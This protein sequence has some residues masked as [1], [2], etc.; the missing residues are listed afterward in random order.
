MQYTKP[1]PRKQDDPA[2]QRQHSLQINK[3]IGSLLQDSGLK[4]VKPDGFVMRT[5][6]YTILLLGMVLLLTGKASGQT[7]TLQGT[8]SLTQCTAVEG[9]NEI[10]YVATS[11]VLRIVNLDSPTQPV[12]S[13]QVATGAGTIAALEAWGNYVYG[14]G[15][16]DGLIIVQASNPASPQLIIRYQPGSSVRDI[17]VYDTLVAYANPA[18]VTLLG[19]RN[20]ANPHV[21]ATYGRAS[22]WV[23]FS[24]NGQVLH[25][26]S[27][28][29][30][31]SL[32]V[33]RNISGGD[34]T[35]SLALDEE[36]STDALTPVSVAGDRVDFVRSSTLVVLNAGTY[37]LFAQRQSS[38]AIRAI[39][40]GNGFCFTALT[41]GELEYLDQRTSPI[42]LVATAVAPASPN[43]IALA[44]S[45]TQPLL[46]VAHNSGVS[47]YSYSAL[48]ADPRFPPPLPT[49]LQWNAFPNPFNAA[50][51][52]RLEAEHPG[53]AE[54]RISDILG[55]TEFS[56]V[57]SVDRSL[58][59][60]YDF[61]GRSA[62]LYIADVRLNGTTAIRKLLYLP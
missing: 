16:G 45:G 17:A 11:G 20:P 57:V 7:L 58:T 35:F 42:Q 38:A 47:V 3:K 48:S 15:L 37:G 10:A 56:E 44:Q 2:I 54:I 1:Y 60:I 40:A 34:T 27:T 4:C 49:S 62:G 22:S 46:V 43:A 33:N 18:N 52:L 59:R 53:Q 8:L 28:A 23:E 30:A 25:V 61:S 13:G 39:A 26:G 55:R 19:V 32:Q 5:R 41:G 31:F 14:A 12:Q 36:Y 50:V 9:A 24:A 51:T 29:G 21:L 6:K